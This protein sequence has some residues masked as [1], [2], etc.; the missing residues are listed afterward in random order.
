MQCCPFSVQYRGQGYRVG[1]REGNG[2]SL[3]RRCWRR[4]SGKVKGDGPAVRMESRGRDG[5]RC[6]RNIFYPSLACSPLP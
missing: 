1:D 4:S 3:V 6:L 5:T 2:K